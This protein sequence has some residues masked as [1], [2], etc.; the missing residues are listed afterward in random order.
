M[1][2]HDAPGGV[3]SKE[4]LTELMPSRL[5]LIDGLRERLDS[6]LKKGKIKELSQEDLAFINTALDEI[7]NQLKGVEALMA[8]SPPQL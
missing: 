5:D 2:T 4:R 7:V 3:I 1:E 6:Y 8:K